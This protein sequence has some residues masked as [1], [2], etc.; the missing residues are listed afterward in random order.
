MIPTS[1]VVN[2]KHISAKIPGGG[3]WVFLLLACFANVT[4]A[5]T[6]RLESQVYVFRNSDAEPVRFSTAAATDDTRSISIYSPATIEFGEKKLSLE[7]AAFSWSGARN[8]P[9]R[10]TLIELPVA[11]TRLNTPV[12]MLSTVPAQYI[13][14]REDG[15]LE[16]RN[17]A[18]DSPD[19]PHCKVSF[20][21][22]SPDHAN[23]ELR[24]SCEVELATVSAREKIPGVNLDVGR[25]LLA[26]FQG[27]VESAVRFGEWS[28]VL[29]RSPNGSEYSLLLLLK[30][31][32]DH[33]SGSTGR[34]GQSG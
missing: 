31:A 3:A 12:A 9:E 30:V 29:F 33:T 8:P 19:A 27:S 32:P 15:T 7:G 21:I 23:A 4:A 11:I 1:T 13:V 18:A 34:T 20:A 25:P 22:R 10:F 17:I 14:K 5:Q 24:V 6:F 2:M 16:L 28:A 26:R